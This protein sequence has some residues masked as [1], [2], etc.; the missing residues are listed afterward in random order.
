MSNPIFGKPGFLDH[1]GSIFKIPGGFNLNGRMGL[2]LIVNTKKMKQLELAAN[3]EWQF[4]VR[5]AFFRGRVDTFI[6]GW[7]FLCR[8]LWGPWFQR[9][10]TC[11][12]WWKA[13]RM[14][15]LNIVSK[16]SIL[17]IMCIHVWYYMI[18]VCIY[19]LFIY[20]FSYLIIYLFNVLFMYLFVYLFIYLFIVWSHKI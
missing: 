9:Y 13:V 5:N 18:Y 19:I 15:E 4:T 20:L 7:W 2:I 14:Q 6:S 17:H 16:H 10:W 3:F 12:K 11:T 1:L 8:Y